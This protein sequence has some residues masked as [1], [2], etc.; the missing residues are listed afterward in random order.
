MT[1]AK[2]AKLVSVAIALDRQIESLQTQ[3]KE[4]KEALV[5]EARSRP[6]AH[7][8]TENG[9][10]SW[11]AQGEDGAIARVTFPGPSLKSKVDSEARGFD[12]IKAAA[13]RA[14]DRLFRPVLSYK[15]VD[16]FRGQA[17]ELLGKDAG[18][19][20]RLCQ[21]ESAPKVGFETKEQA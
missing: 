12:K 3:L 20:V 4:C 6:E 5:T 19:L 11:V 16:D 2:L 14:F 8:P 1:E 18:K 9:G 15:P 17:S 13:G 7:T 21:S 10:T